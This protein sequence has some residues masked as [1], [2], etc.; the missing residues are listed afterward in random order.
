MAEYWKSLFALFVVGMAVST[1]AAQQKSEPK[2]GARELAAKAFLE[3]LVKGEFAKATNQFDAAMLKALPPDE[4]KKTWE[5]VQ[6]DAGAFQR[7]VGSRFETSGQFDIVRVTCE[8]AHTKRD[9]RVVFDKDGKITGLFFAPIKKPLP[10]GIEEI[11]EGT[12][13]AGMVEIRLVFHLFKQKDGSYAGTLDSPDQGAKNLVLDEVRVNGDSV[14]LELK[15]AKMVFE[16][17]RA[18]D[19]QEIAGELKQV[20]QAFPLTL[21]KVAK[22]TESKRPQNPQQPYPYDEVEARYENKKAGIRLAG[23]LTVPRS[24]GPFPAVL[25]ISGSGPQDRDETIFGHKPFLVLAD[26]LTR[27][28]IAVLRVDD[29]GMGGSTGNT[30]ESTSED[31]A[32]DVLAGVNWLKG[33]KEI[34]TSKIGL[35]GHSEGGIIAP[36]VASRSHDIAFIVLLAGS[37]LPGEEILYLQAAALLKATGA[38][39]EEIATAKAM[40]KHIFSLL[41]QEK[42]KAAAETK[43]RAAMNDYLA[44]LGND[45][46]KKQLESLP[47]MES[48][49]HMVVSPWFRYFLDYDPRQALRKVPCPVLALNGEKDLQVDA[50]ANLKAIEAALKEGGNKDVT[51]QELPNVNHLFQTC[52]TGAISEYAA[53]EETLAPAALETI[54]TWIQK[55][56]RISAAH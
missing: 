5:K 37:G 28:G 48:Q 14:H 4:L 18:K 53:L 54:A 15:S 51:I 34:D 19:G 47:L 6:S 27:R 52:K 56:T 42:D 55:R 38:D 41:R 46:K 2:A 23:T 21:K 43:I 12:L 7:Q 39:A 8:F 44:K 36:L 30:M 45:E 10:T 3:L 49:I 17:K 1:V 11:W 33:R 13:K 50:K 25:L 16:G 31:S 29:R 26:Y 35:L 22:A 40:Q 24:G 32:E 20:G 9:A